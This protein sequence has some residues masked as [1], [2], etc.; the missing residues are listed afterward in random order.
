[1]S[2]GKA[3]PWGG[4]F[5]QGQSS[6]VESFTESVSYDRLLYKQDIAGSKAHARMLAARGV[7]SSQ[8]AQSIV[9]GLDQVLAAIE[10]GDFAWKKELEDVHM[11]IERR[12]SEL[13]GDAGKR[14]HT[15]RSRNDQVALDFRLY[16]SERL[17]DWAA[18]CVDLI[19][20]FMEQAQEHQHVLLPG[21]THMQP[22]QPVSLAHHL[23]AY[24]W[25]LRRDHERITDCLK[26][27]RVSP[28]G[29]A[30][31][32][33]T[34]YPLD[35]EAV[36][37][38]LG[39]HKIFDNSMDAVAD[40]DFAAEALFAA[41]LCMVHLSRFCEELIIWA[42]PNF[43]YVLLPDAYATG[44]SIMPQKKNPDVA[45]LVRGKVG[46]VQGALVSLLTTLKAL[47]LAYNRDMQEDK[48][49][50]FDA[51]TT[52]STSLELVAGMVRALRFNE[53]AMRAALD[54]G[55]CNATELADYLVG[56]GVPFRDAH[57]AT[58]KAVALAEETNRRLE[59]LTL[60]ELRHCA[61][62][63][64]EDVYAVLPHEAAVQRRVTHGSTGP[65][66]VRTQLG[67]LGAW[68]EA[69]PR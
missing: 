18:L 12:L 27:V 31:L 45:E 13:A 14:L 63:V 40:R 30:A 10:S 36:A 48:E 51:D 47:P 67:A 49:P 19:R 41:N 60:D 58:G 17:D 7:I 4:R 5:R 56:K 6:A 52:L 57:H 37:R 9:A 43:G 28:L 24:A 1:M 25:M 33:G 26:R 44:S 35:P 50:F 53:Q 42:N 65:D 62:E 38:E 32:A 69:Q 29:A 21:C 61:T 46:R 22:A 55:F 23:L 66:A 15:G 8:D 59:D 39:F 68:V 3:K 2:S 54:Q 34:T 64:G 16:V 11:N 20:A